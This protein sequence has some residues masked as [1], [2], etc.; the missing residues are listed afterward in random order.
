MVAC[1]RLTW[2]I[3]ALLVTSLP[4]L[5]LAQEVNFGVVPAEVRINNLPSGETT[6]FNLTVTNNN[7]ITR[8]FTFSACEPSEEEA[9][10]L[11]PGL[12]DASWLSFS[13]PEIAVAPGT[14]ANVTVTIAIPQDHKW[15]GKDWETWL[16]VA[17]KSDDLLG[18]T[19][20]VRLLVSTS[21]TR[22]SAGFI[23]GIAA[24]AALIGYGSYRYFKRRTRFD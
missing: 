20:Y 15:A 19:L 12:P 23:A 21:G 17:A 11:R 22:L 13:P 1:V 8:V 5:A 2:L 14:Q 4:S 16:G 3:A 6:A 18:V 9:R 7:E 24:G 10:E